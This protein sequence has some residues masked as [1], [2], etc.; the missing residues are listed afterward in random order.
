MTVAAGPNKLQAGGSI[1][2]YVFRRCES[3]RA[4]LR[5]QAT[6]HKPTKNNGVKSILGATPQ[7]HDA[8]QYAQQSAVYLVL[9]LF[10]EHASWILK[11][12]ERRNKTTLSVRK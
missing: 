4:Y 12:R 9:G 1:F 5:R 7:R 11:A 2:D 10:T 8:R 3:S 6:S